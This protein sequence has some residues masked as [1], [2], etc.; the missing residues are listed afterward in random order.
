MTVTANTTRNE[1]S[2][3]TNQNEYSYNFQLNDETDVKVLLGGVLQTLNADYTVEGVGVGSGGTITFTLTDSDNNP[4]FPTQGTQI[5]IFHA[6]DLDRDTAFQQ[7]GLILADEI[8]NDYDRLWLACNQQQTAIN[9]S[10]RLK[11]ED[12]ASG[13]L[14]LPL[15]ED[16]KGKFLGFDAT[17]GEPVTTEA[18]DGTGFV[19]KTGATMTGLLN[20]TVGYAVGGTTFIDSGRQ[21]SNVS[22]AISQFTNDS[23]FLNNTSTIDAGNF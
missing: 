5:I 8:N 23:N 17:T 6:M 19:E 1:Y 2:A 13:T 11:D 9:R 15:T 7:N 14:E 18:F 21:L 10:L 12:V 20:N 22:G 4:I 3:G 16:R